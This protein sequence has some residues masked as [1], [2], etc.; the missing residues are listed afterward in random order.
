MARRLALV[1]QNALLNGDL[2]RVCSVLQDLQDPTSAQLAR[3]PTRA[4]EPR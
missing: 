1:A 2:Q 4:A 3:K